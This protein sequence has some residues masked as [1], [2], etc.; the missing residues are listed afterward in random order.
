MVLGRQERQPEWQILICLIIAYEL[1]NINI[2][3]NRS[4]RHHNA[5]EKGVEYYEFVICVYSLVCV[6]S[7][8]FS[9]HLD[10]C[11]TRDTVLPVM[12]GILGQKG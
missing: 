4:E 10:V 7:T 5:L 2:A 1:Q 12:F 6:I 3:C 11:Y 8:A 9:G